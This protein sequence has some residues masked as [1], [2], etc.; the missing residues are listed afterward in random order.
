MPELN[1]NHVK[2]SYMLP[3]GNSYVRGNFIIRKEIQMVTP[4]EG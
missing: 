1:D 4:L 3:R 2:Y